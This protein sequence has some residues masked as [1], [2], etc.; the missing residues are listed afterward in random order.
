[1]DYYAREYK[2]LRTRWIN[3]VQ[4]KHPKSTRQRGYHGCDD[5]SVQFF[6]KESGKL[7]GDYDL[8]GYY[9]L[10]EIYNVKLEEN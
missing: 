4:K 10:Q 5:Y 3:E 9:R 6:C 2:K 7:L 8:P 1:M